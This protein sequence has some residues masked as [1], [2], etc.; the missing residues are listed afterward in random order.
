MTRYLLTNPADVTAMVRCLDYQ[1]VAPLEA[2][3]AEAADQPIGGFATHRLTGRI[4]HRTTAWPRSKPAW[5]PICV[6]QDF[7]AFEE[8][9]G[10]VAWS[11]RR[12]AVMHPP[13]V[14]ADRGVPAMLS[15]SQISADERAATDLVQALPRQVV[16]PIRALRSWQ[17][18]AGITE[19]AL[20][21]RIWIP[22]RGRD[23]RNTP[24]PRVGRT[25]IDPG[26][27]ARI[28][29][30]RAAAAGFDPAATRRPQPQ[31]PRVKRRHGSR[32]PPDPPQAAPDAIRATPCWTAILSWATCSR[33]T[34]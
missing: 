18:A 13:S 22:P 1:T 4:D 6:A 21:R 24:L 5:C 28:V 12:G 23:R 27:V 16:C 34:R 31:A 25:A 11:A 29:Q 8:V 26:T 15:P 9:Y 32:R 30:A 33:G 17:H 10:R 7:A 14:S 3:L 19:G 2:A 20:F